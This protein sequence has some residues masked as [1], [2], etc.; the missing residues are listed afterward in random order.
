MRKEGREDK[1]EDEHASENEPEHDTQPMRKEG[2]K[3]VKIMP[4][5]LIYQV[6]MY[7]SNRKTSVRRII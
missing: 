2:R 3:A 5:M 6:E 4:K 1:H 7:K